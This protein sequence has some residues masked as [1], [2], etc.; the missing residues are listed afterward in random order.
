VEASMHMK[1]SGGHPQGSAMH[2]MPLNRNLEA[3]VKI[4]S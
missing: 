2:L 4:I 1:F 3:H